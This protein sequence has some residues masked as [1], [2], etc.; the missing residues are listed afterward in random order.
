MFIDFKILKSQVYIIGYRLNILTYYVNIAF[1]DE[2]LNKKLNIVSPINT[3]VNIL[4]N[5]HMAKHNTEHIGL[6]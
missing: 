1:R 3:K 5:V 4:Y 2:N 6:I